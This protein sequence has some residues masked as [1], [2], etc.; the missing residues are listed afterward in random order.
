[1][2]NAVWYNQGQNETV[3][4]TITKRKSERCSCFDSPAAHL[5]S[6]VVQVEEVP[7]YGIRTLK[8]Y[9]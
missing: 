2:L 1:M 5:I 4:S 6:S 9:A 7:Y 3:Y 8:P